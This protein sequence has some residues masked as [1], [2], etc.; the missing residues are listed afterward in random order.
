VEAAH[1]PREWLDCRERAAREEVMVS[2]GSASGARDEGGQR[3][4]CE[5]GTRARAPRETRV[6]LGRV[7]RCVHPRRAS[8][9]LQNGRRRHLC[10][11]KPSERAG[12]KGRGKAART[13]TCT[14]AI[15][16][17]DD[18]ATRR[19]DIPR[20]VNWASEWRE[21]SRGWLARFGTR[22]PR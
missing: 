17:Q 13:R 4:M 16:S 20:S 9:I 10:Y 3:H 7:E 11:T 12:R 19:I 21:A 1:A 6:G 15:P 18:V 2:V 5:R 14:T 8:I 22:R